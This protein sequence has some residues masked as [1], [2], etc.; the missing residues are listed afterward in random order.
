[1]EDR[2]TKIAELMHDENAEDIMKLAFL[3]YGYEEEKK[4]MIEEQ[5]GESNES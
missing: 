3:M 1:M 4:R 5:E 2:K